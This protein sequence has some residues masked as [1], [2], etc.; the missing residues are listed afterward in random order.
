M[1]KNNQI[2]SKGFN[3]RNFGASSS[4]RRPANNTKSSNNSGRT[5]SGEKSR[6]EERASIPTNNSGAVIL[7]QGREQPI[8]KRHHW[9]F[10]GGI[11]STPIYEP[12]DILPV[13][14]SKGELL[15][16]A[17]FNPFSDIAGRMV[18][19]GEEDPISYLRDQVSKAV[20]LRSALF[21]L[22]NTNSYRLIN[23]EGDGVPGLVVDRYNNVLVIQSSTAGMDKLKSQI[24]EWLLAELPEIKTVYERSEIAS[25]TK[26]KLPQI[27]EYLYGEAIS[28]V[29]ILENG[30]KMIVDFVEGHKTGYYLD[31]R[32]MRSL[33]GEL[34]TGKRVLNCFSYTGGFSLAAA[35]GSALSTN[36]V[37]LSA[38]AL[39]VAKRNFELNGFSGDHSFNSADVF[40]FLRE[41]DLNYD[42]VILDPPAFA[43]K[44][45]DIEAA[46]R[47]YRDINRI[48]MSKMPAGSMLITCSCSYHID[49]ELFERIVQQAANDA[50][51][52]VKII[53]KHRMAMDH[54]LSVHHKEADY[55]K[56]LVLWVD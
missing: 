53:H 40:K 46:T 13:K 26:E 42:L 15:G 34:A 16:Y 23:G 4:L 51:R 37:D 19:F 1:Q 21:D 24:V 43:K 50:K 31:Q 39:E 9:I 35:R 22:S 48:A 49:Q 8:I 25:R 5:F 45:T 10:S 11:Q 36:S 32:E 14:T 20:S 54:V 6:D 30:L 17:Y 47:G 27:K 2:S 29:E 3:R 52:S 28:E 41:E 18:S 12:G 55:L 56:S 38:Q 44:R 33:V 7:Q